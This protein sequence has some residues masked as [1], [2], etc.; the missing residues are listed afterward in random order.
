MSK[1]NTFLEYSRA[2]YN[3]TVYVKE[4]SRFMKLLFSV[5]LMQFWNPKFMSS[6]TNVLSTPW[7]HYIFMP[8]ELHDTDSGYRVL[9]HELVHAH[10]CSGWRWP[11]YVVSYC[12]LPIG[13]SFRAFWELRA[14]R[15]SMEAFYEEFGELPDWY[16]KFIANEFTGPTYL[17]MFP[18]PKTIMQI[19]DQYRIKILGNNL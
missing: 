3:I 2:K 4:D 15:E 8:R 9:R 14:Y 10:D 17:Y 7:S 1:Y 16:L 19:L 5:L 12:I 6:Y 18:F 11:L 13:P